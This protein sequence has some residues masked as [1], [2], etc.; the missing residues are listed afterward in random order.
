MRLLSILD[1]IAQDMRYGARLLRKSPGFTLVAIITLAVGIGSAAATFSI[2]DSWLIRALPLKDADQLYA[3]WRSAPG[4]PAQPAFFFGYRDYLGFSRDARSFSEIA[5]SFHRS[6]TVTGIA[7]PEGVDGEIATANLFS[8]LGVKAAQGRTFLPEDAAGAKVA[9]VSHGFWERKLGASSSVVG[10]TLTMNDEAY[11]V[12]GV[13]PKEFSYRVLD[14]P[15][16]R[17]VWTLIQPAD[18]MYA[19]GS[20]AAV[21]IVGRLRGGVTPDQAQAELNNIRQEM[22]NQRSPVPEV[23]VGT[24]TLVAGLR[25]DNTRLVRSS[26]LL[27]AAAIG[28][29]LLIACSNTAALVV[30]RNS[31]RRAEFAVRAALGSGSRRLLAQLLAENLVLYLC[32][33]LL[34]LLL[35]AAAVYGFKLWNPLRALPARGVDLSLRT[36]AAAAALTLVTSMSF[37]ALPALQG[38][39][40]N[41]SDSLRAGSRGITT[42]RSHLRVQTWMVGAQIALSLVLLAGAGLLVSTLVS[43][44][45]QWFDFETG[46]AQAFR[47]SLPN[48]RYK[49]QEKAVQFE[50]ALLTGLRETPGVRF[51]ALSPMLGYGDAI[52]TP[53][54]ISNRPVEQVRDMPHAV[55]TTI[56]SQ[57]FRAAKIP[58]LRGQDFPDSLEERSEAVAVVNEEAVRLDFAGAD[59]IGQ[60]VRLGDPTDA[61]TAK[62]PWCRIIGLVGDT[63]SVAYNHLAWETRPEIYVDFRQVPPSAS[64][65]PWGSRMLNFIVSTFPGAPVRLDELQQAVWSLDAELPVPPPESLESAVT[66]R[67]AQPRTRAQLLIVFASISLFLTAIG[68]YGVL[69]ESVVRRQ[70]ELAIRMSLGATRAEISRLVLSRS[71]AVAAAGVLVGTMVALGGARAVRSMVYGIS[72]FNPVLYCSAGL[73]LLLVA[74]LAAYLPARR[75]ASVDP[76]SALRGD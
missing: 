36:L 55:I 48:T 10:Q 29:V 58:M 1:R 73:L 6:Y 56:S 22:D 68:V 20:D 33:A 5:A 24:A 39:R 75:A 14:E 15:I 63:R 54:A 16:D 4:S 66:T 71:L 69:S 27:L 8:T 9:V 37:G 17:D 26:L 51:A 74:V 30:G 47:L 31:G 35:A 18:P 64:A 38:T 11:L 41:L 65:G 49:E 53:F 67:L 43:L 2:L 23:F 21:G 62:H 57:F 13:L 45:H 12:I 46:N 28:C 3:V 60:H 40:L 19:A 34:G 42:G 59:P 72:A 61:G 25:Q 76:M 52:Q 32:G 50:E 7:K 44:E 70:P